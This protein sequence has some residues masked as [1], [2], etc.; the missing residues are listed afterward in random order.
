MGRELS[1]SMGLGWKLLRYR[2]ER[3]AK[4]LKG[5]IKGSVSSNRNGGRG[6]RVRLES[7][8]ETLISEP[9]LEEGS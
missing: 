7:V 6:V 1:R 8:N 9:E 3:G 4:E 2:W 5:H